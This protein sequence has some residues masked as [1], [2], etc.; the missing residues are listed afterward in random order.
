MQAIIVKLANCW[1]VFTP[2]NY[3]LLLPDFIITQLKK[4]HFKS[5]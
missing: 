3:L 5:V 2:T 1:I 4:L